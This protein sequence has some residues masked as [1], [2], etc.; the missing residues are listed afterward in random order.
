[1]KSTKLICFALIFACFATLFQPIED[2]IA[3]AAGAV[4]RVAAGGSSN[5]LS[6][7]LTWDTPCALEYTL[8]ARAGEN[9]EIWVKAGTYTP[10][11]N[12]VSTQSFHLTSG[13]GLY[14][15]FSGV[16]TSREQRNW[17]DNP[18]YLTGLHGDPHP[19]DVLMSSFA[20]ELTVLDGFTVSGDSGIHVDYG[21][22]TLRN[23]T[24]RN[25]QYA[26]NGGGLEN[27]GGVVTIENV[28]FIDNIA[29]NGGAIYSASGS[30]SI[31]DTLFQNNAAAPFGYGGAIWMIQ[32][33]HLE[34]ENTSFIGNS[35]RMGGAIFSDEGTVLITNSVFS[36]NNTTVLGGT[37]ANAFG[38]VTTIISSTFR[39]NTGIGPGVSIY[40]WQ[41]FSLVV[42]NSILWETQ[43]APIFDY[44]GLS[45]A[46]VAYS[47][48][49]GG[50]AGVQNID[51]DPGFGSVGNYGGMTPTI[52]ISESSPAKDA[53]PEEFCIWADGSPLSTDQ[54]GILRPQDFGCD[55]G[56]FEVEDTQVNLI[57]N[58]LVTLKVNMP[59]VITR[60][61]LRISYRDDRP[62]Q[63]TYTISQLPT[64]GRLRLDGAD[65]Q[66][67]DVFTQKDIDDGKL[68]Y[69]NDSGSPGPDGFGFLFS[70]PGQPA[71][72]RVS[73]G[74]EGEQANSAS[75]NAK[76]SADG[77]YFVF[78][79][80]ATNLASQD[81]YGIFQVYLR[82]Q[83]EDLTS[84]VSVSTEGNAGQGNSMI[85][86]ISPNGRFTAFSSDA[87]NFGTNPPSSTLEL[88]F[89]DHLQQPPAQELVSVSPSDQPGN[90]FSY[91]S[92]ISGDGRYVVFQTEATNL[93]VGLQ[94]EGSALILRDRITHEN[95]CLAT[96]LNLNLCR[97]GVFP[98]ISEDG[99]W[100][101]FGTW[102]SLVS[103][104]TNNFR[105]AY[106]YR[107]ADQSLQ[108]VS[109]G[110]DGQAGNHQSGI[111]TI[112]ISGD[113]NFVLYGSDASNLTAGDTN[114]ETDLFVYD[115]AADST[116]LVTVN[117]KQEQAIYN[118][119]AFPG[120]ASAISL[121][122]RYVAFLSSA[123]N[124]DLWDL[125][126]EED[127]FLRDRQNQT[128]NRVVLPRQAGDATPL[129]GDNVLTLGLAADGKKILFGSAA[130]WLVDD[131][132]NAAADFFVVNLN[133][134]ARLRIQVD[135]RSPAP[136]IKINNGLSI[137]NGLTKTI[138][139]E[140]ILASSGLPAV[141]TV[142]TLT[143]IPQNGSL[144]LDHQPLQVGNTF[145][146]EDINQGKL[147]FH[148]VQPGSDEFT[149]ALGFK[150]LIQR[151]SVGPDGQ[152]NPDS[153]F[154]YPSIS[155]DGRYTP[156]T[157]TEDDQTVIFVRD[158]ETQQ[159]ERIAPGSYGIISGNSRYV[160]FLS[161]TANI[162]PGIQP[163]VYGAHLYRYDRVYKSFEIIDVD[164][165]GNPSSEGVGPAIGI[166]FDGQEVLFGAGS[167]LIPGT[168]EISVYV[169]HMRTGELELA[170]IDTGNNPVT[171]YWS[172]ISGDGRYV[173]F[174]NY[175]RDMKT[176]TTTQ[177]LLSAR[178]LFPMISYNGQSI[179][180][181]IEDGILPGD[182]NGFTDIA[183]YDQ[184]VN[185]YSLIS[186]TETGHSANGT[187]LLP[188]ISPDGRYVSFST[189]AASLSGLTH[190]FIG[191]VVLHDRVTSINKAVSISAGGVSG[192]D[193]S[194]YT[195]L[196]A[197]GQS[198]LFSSR[199][200]N[201]VPGEDETNG[202]F[203][204]D[205][206]CNF[207]SF[208]ITVE[209]GWQL[210]M[211]IISR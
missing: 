207:G 148:A 199:S 141:N 152:V 80:N 176:K 84:L 36:G 58:S 145:T 178:D 72:E 47:D 194:A 155:Y 107:V 106:L 12:N 128:T 42:R 66:I 133:Q 1:M 100:A 127:L 104:D 59:V 13:V 156:I 29:D 94:T 180:S 49:K 177:T 71:I 172:S 158:L 92:S 192:N 169:R 65:L 4:I 174:E 68:V 134:Q 45:S 86:A 99:E 171:P 200:S 85:P 175:I 6:C 38:S 9:D 206:T 40:T 150:P 19:Y 30:L 205:L 153:Y 159:Y 109:K 50:Y 208:E 5:D 143:G 22:L 113:G 89:Q 161:D 204:V 146:Q 187:S 91:F 211:P 37:I 201:L 170:S 28:Q 70:A 62:D 87:S 34:L 116:E 184:A 41:G 46:E 114:G 129:F 188:S 154:W 31:K 166:S 23:M 44:G 74:S 137:Q 139:P 51:S 157:L 135:S 17:I 21:Y 96:D 54:R 55:M 82:D 163:P 181:T 32:H 196:P 138:S 190:P 112:S 11:G 81:T 164:T 189:D 8:S 75:Y 93:L 173:V 144:T 77:R 123:S 147:A 24:I 126:D 76:M 197:G 168:P 108:L 117:S 39:D 209:Q 151:I 18:T 83:Q 60:E 162:I 69:Y 27:N 35:A 48:I 136:E 198:I 121:D 16:E 131:D 64:L 88:F 61:E 52:P 115:R 193:N 10:S 78:D 203:F 149:F 210:F 20:G 25:N 103:E 118:Q 102:A 191:Q 185:S 97:G 179:V 130:D 53:V 56:S 105:D 63:L 26:G 15:G 67:N 122:G 3:S 119:F 98:V 33:T 120:P 125:N 165:N 160:L 132:T 73:V 43:D 90:G 195:A 142:F 111:G 186:V 167:S 2:P 183:L 57:R 182:N 110:M 202:Q 7:G 101:A 140:Q 14:G 95:R 124:L 79:S